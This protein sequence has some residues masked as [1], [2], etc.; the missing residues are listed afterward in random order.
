MARAREGKNEQL[1]LEIVEDRNGAR[2]TSVNKQH[3]LISFS[4]RQ[5][6]D[7]E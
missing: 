6:Q 1:L 2:L 7:H 3:P 4:A 5:D